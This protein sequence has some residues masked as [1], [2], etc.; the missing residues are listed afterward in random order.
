MTSWPHWNLI[1][2]SMTV[3]I[4][5]VKSWTI[6]SEKQKKTKR[7]WFLSWNSALPC[8]CLNHNGIVNA[9]CVCV[10]EISF[11][12]WGASGCI[13]KVWH[14]KHL[15]PSCRLLL[16]LLLSLFVFMF[17]YHHCVV[18]QDIILFAFILKRGVLF[19]C[20][21]IR[22]LFFSCCSPRGSTSPAL[23]MPKRQF[24]E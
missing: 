18:F 14:F 6:G 19:Y 5:R 9:Q 7:P 20:V 3:I 2:R 24:H 12:D 11:E 8:Y 23:W 1:P 22:F 4:R 13:R 21:L 17:Y 16:L 10:S 15:L